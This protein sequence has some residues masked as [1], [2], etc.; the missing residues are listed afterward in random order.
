MRC[1]I[2]EWCGANLDFGETC[3]CRMEDKGDDKEDSREEE[4]DETVTTAT[5]AYA[6]AEDCYYGSRPQVEKLA[7]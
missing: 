1:K 5:E 6:P 4:D 2:C 3:D 7:G